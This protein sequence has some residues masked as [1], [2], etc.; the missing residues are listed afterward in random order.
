MKQTTL[1]SSAAKAQRSSSVKKACQI[2]QAV[3][4]A[5]TS[6]LTGIALKAGLDKA[7]TLRLLEMLT[8][9]GFVVRD[10]RTKLYSLGPELQALGAAA[11]ARFDP[12]PIVQPSLLRLANQFEDTVLLS[13]PRG[14][15]SLCLAVEE[16]RFP[17]RANYLPVGGRRLLGVGAGSLALLAWMPAREYDAVLPAIGAALC[18]HP[19]LSRRLIEKK[20]V[21]SRRL[22]YAITLNIV[23]DRMGGV[24]APII[25]TDGRPVAALS[26]AALSDRIISRQAEIVAA[27]KR[28]VAICQSLWR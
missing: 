23:V 13:V 7:T 4:A 14:N 27:L 3:S 2:L 24:G 1:K 15:E 5:S 22:G 17:I 16:G 12:R 11:L 18:D 26:I 21:E 20:V 8:Q 10:L 25:G 19:R 28:E 6:R 9:E